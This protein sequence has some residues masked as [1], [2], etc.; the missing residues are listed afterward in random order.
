MLIKQCQFLSKTAAGT[1]FHPLFGSYGVFEKVA[2][3]PPFADWA[4]GEHIRKFIS[5]LSREDREKNAYAL[6][7][8]L[9]A[10]EYY[11]SNINADYFPWDALAHEG[12]DYGHQTFLD[13]HAFQHHVN[14]DPTRAFGVPKLAMINPQMKRVELI[15][16]LDREKARAEKADSVLTRIDHGEFPDV[17]MGCKVP[18]DVCMVRS[19]ANRSKTKDDYCVH[20]RPPEDLRDVY[21]PN[22]VLPDGQKCCVSNT[23]P[24][25]FDIS[26]VFIGADKTA[27][28]MAKLA[29]VKKGTSIYYC[30]GDVCSIVRGSAEVAEMVESKAP[31]EKAACACTGP[32]CEEKLASVF[33]K[34]AGE[35]FSEMMKEIPASHFSAHEVPELSKAE[36]DLETQALEKLKS[37]PVGTAAGTLGGLGIVLKPQEFQTLILIK[38]GENQLEQELRTKNQVFR[39]TPQ[40]NRSM[41]LSFDLKLAHQ[42]L[43]Q[44]PSRSG[45]GK[46]LAMRASGLNKT[47]EMTLPTPS[48]LTHPLL[49]EISAA[50]NGYRQN[51]LMKIAQA[52]D[53]IDSDPQLRDALQGRILVDMFA[54]TA[55]PSLISLDSVAYFAGA[56]SDRSLLSNTAVAMEV[57][58]NP[59]LQSHIGPE[60]MT[61]KTAPPPTNTRRRS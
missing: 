46:P 11:G 21:G 26:F 25:F 59:W 9:G 15:V 47:G 61:S 39:S 1:F 44:V 23:L 12:R 19:C 2:G 51:L 4:T 28:V 31:M 36:P 35:K 50:Y 14:K 22:K 7:N 29:E 60:V 27:K 3:A 5:K 18:Y 24:R 38:M 37:V 55:S 33:G 57:A 40:V 6:L 41:E 13:A 53:A 56:H 17:S 43:D 42:L 58:A 54:K 34:S 32:C 30:M 45:F 20:M 16:A 10:G 49:D 8:A 52:A 48:E